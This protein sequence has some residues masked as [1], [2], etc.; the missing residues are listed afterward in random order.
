[1][2][3]LI[4]ANLPAVLADILIQLGHE[5]SHTIT[6]PDGNAT[7]D[8]VII[9][10]IGDRTIVS[11]DSDF[12]QSFLVKRIPRKLIFVK[13][14]NM[15]GKVLLSLFRKQAKKMIDLLSQYDCLELHHDKIIVID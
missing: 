9:K 1:M 2:K 4:D 10:I 6:L 12:Y 3:F 14:G 13:V 5:A 8:E 15:R 11:K 7:Q